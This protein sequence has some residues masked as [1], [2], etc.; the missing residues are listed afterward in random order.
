M[1]FIGRVRFFATGVGKGDS[2]I[3]SDLLKGPITDWIDFS[4][5]SETSR[6]VSPFGKVCGSLAFLMEA[7]ECLTEF[8]TEWRIAARASELGFLPWLKSLIAFLC[9]LLS[10][11]I[12]KIPCARMIEDTARDETLFPASCDCRDLGRV[13]RK[14]RHVIVLPS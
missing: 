1:G 8:C 7:N 3:G 9:K 13:L 6:D 14:Y 5:H 11:V 2:Q 10:G 4:V 12:S